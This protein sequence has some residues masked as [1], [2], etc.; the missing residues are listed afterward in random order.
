[1]G[2]EKGHKKEGLKAKGH[3]GKSNKEKGKE[4]ALEENSHSGKDRENALEEKVLELEETLKRVQAE[5]ENSRKRLEREKGE[6]A[7]VANA[8]IVKDLLPLLDSMDSATK[9]FEEREKVGKEEAE[10]GIAMV[11][12]QLLAILGA[13][14]LESIKCFG[15]KFDPMLHDCVMKGEEKGREDDVVLEELQKGYLLNGKVLRHAKVK[16]NKK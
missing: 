11:K 2:R 1:M 13:Y 10:E 14:G 7:K 12:K 5:F 4:K 6:F 16:V 9:G 3:A 15:K 8:R